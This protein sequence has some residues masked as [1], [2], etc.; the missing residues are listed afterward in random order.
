MYKFK[1]LAKVS[2]LI[3]LHLKCLVVKCKEIKKRRKWKRLKKGEKEK[4][5][6]SNEREERWRNKSRL[7]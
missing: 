3:F 2:L 6:L 5:Q 1:F 4:E 7:T